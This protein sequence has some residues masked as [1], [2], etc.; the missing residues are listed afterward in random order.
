MKKVVSMGELL[1]DFIP[2]EKGV[3]LK[4]VTEFIKMPGGAPANVA[5]TVSKL[6]GESAFIGQVGQDAFGDYLKET[7]IEKG[8]DVSHLYQTD[9]AKTALAFVSLALDGQRDFMFYR[10]PS[11]D[12]L[13]SRDLVDEDFLKSTIFHFCSVSL[14]DHPIKD[15]HKFAIESL[16]KHQGFI[17]FDPNIRL[18]LW[19]DH[20]AYKK[21]INTFIP[22]A[23]LLK[24][25]DDEL[26]FITEISDKKKAI[27]SLFVGDVSY[28]ILT[29]GR[30]GAELHTKKNVYDISGFDVKVIDTTGAGDAFIGAI[31]YQLAQKDAL[32]QINDHEFRKIVR[33]AN[34]CAA[35]TTTKLGAMSAIPTLEEI[36]ALIKEQPLNV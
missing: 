27:D 35:L 6:G 3:F 36:E 12:Q 5:A 1:I 15:A 10:D 30:D 4:E 9:Q 21:V 17:S 28:I 33:F 25:S 8:I 26:Y 29:K 20:V 22:F 31:L 16:K 14:T 18:P 2:K 32:D 7:L 13:F 34:A 23:N 24:I 11:A 19:K